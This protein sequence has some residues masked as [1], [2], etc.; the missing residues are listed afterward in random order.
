MS[1][2]DGGLPKWIEKGYPTVSGPQQEVPT[3]TYRATYHPELYRTLEQMMENHSSRKE[4]VGVY[5]PVINIGQP[6]QDNPLLYFF[7]GCMHDVYF[8]HFF[9]GYAP[10]AL[11]FN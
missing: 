1:I 3:S 7:G 9:P 4:Q 8:S 2:L 6:M 11:W 10:I 5:T